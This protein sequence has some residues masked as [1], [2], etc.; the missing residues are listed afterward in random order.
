MVY[1][2]P[3]HILIV[4]N[5]YLEKLMPIQLKVNCVSFLYNLVPSLNCWHG[6]KDQRVYDLKIKSDNGARL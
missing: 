6:L 4:I 5:M 3:K 2:W 1:L